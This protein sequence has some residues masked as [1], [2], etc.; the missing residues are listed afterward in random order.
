MERRAFLGTVGSAAVVGLAGC[1]G[2]SSANQEYDVGMGAKVF[3]P[4]E[5]E[6]EPGTTLT[7]LNTS[8]QGHT[9][10]A[11]ENQLPES[12]E[13]FASGDF[14]SEQAARD[15]WGNSTKGTLFEGQS[16]SHTFEIPGTYPYFCIPHERGGMV[17]LV[18]VTENPASLSHS[19]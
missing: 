15:A 1:L 12:A 10:T 13:F 5:I 8:K 7:W 19:E 11:Y 3:R 2:S 17:G 16:F 4:Q 14:E 6:I 9:V 18:V